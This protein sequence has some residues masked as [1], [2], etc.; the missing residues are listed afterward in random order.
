MEGVCICAYML[1]SH[2][3]VWGGKWISGV[4]LQ[5][6]YKSCSALASHWLRHQTA[7]S[8]RLK[9]LDQMCISVSGSLVS[10]GV[11]AHFKNSSLIKST[12]PSLMVTH[13]HDHRC[14]LT[15]L[16]ESCWLMA[17]ESDGNIWLVVSQGSIRCCWPRRQ[18]ACRFELLLLSCFGRAS[19]T[20]PLCPLVPFKVWNA[21]SG[22]LGTCDWLY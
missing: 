17:A 15:G 21:L 4:K 8:V 19:V 1:T 9:W 5:S 22:L 3:Y 2:V 12:K 16:S 18:R 14:L 7:V 13:A 11:S 20:L 10:A 6:H